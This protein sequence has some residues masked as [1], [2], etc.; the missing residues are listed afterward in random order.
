MSIRD[1]FWPSNLK[2]NIVGILIFL[3]PVFFL[4]IRGWTNTVAISLIIFS[5]FAIL[6]NAN[7]YLRNRRPQTW[8][9]TIVFCVPLLCETSVQTLRFLFFRMEPHG[10]SIDTVLRFAA[11]GICFLYLSRHPTK[12]LYQNLFVGCFLGLLVCL[13]YPLLG[14]LPWRESTRASTYFVD[15]NSYGIYVI[16]LGALS[17]FGFVG[18]KAFWSQFAK[19]SALF[20]A[21]SI[22]FNSE[23]RS[24]LLASFGLVLGVMIYEFQNK[25]RIR[26][27]LL[28]FFFLSLLVIYLL[29]EF[30]TWRIGEIYPEI[31]YF[32]Q[33]TNPK[34][35][36][37]GSRIDLIRLDFAMFA[38]SPVLGWPDGVV[39][40]D[41]DLFSVI[42]HLAP[43]TTHIKVFS[44]SHVEPLNWLVKQGILG[45]FSI[46]ALYGIAW[47]AVYLKYRRHSNKFTK[48]GFSALAVSSILFLAGFGV[49]VFNLKMNIT[50][51]SLC[52]AVLLAS[53][54]ADSKVELDRGDTLVKNKN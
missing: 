44:G 39:P 18:S 20:I 11:A 23:S 50:F 25:I 33:T 19:F 32:F 48:V 10:P 16:V 52:L 42:T 35:T 43:D 22:A 17:Y 15:P 40:Q 8:I 53:M 24:A 27:I 13:I 5:S 21:L 1:I 38:L 29:L 46:L 54:C 41:S 28:W 6:Q 30:D 31:N 47:I 26:S 2:E 14:G 49:Q 12:T 4:T 3:L 37:I 45:V 36:S 51:F 7:L 34:E 9:I